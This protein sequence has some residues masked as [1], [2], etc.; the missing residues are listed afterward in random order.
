MKEREREWKRERENEREKER[1]RK[2]GIERVIQG[3]TGD[4]NYYTKRSTRQFYK[5]RLPSILWQ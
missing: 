5:K 2:R 4:T 1:V 3:N